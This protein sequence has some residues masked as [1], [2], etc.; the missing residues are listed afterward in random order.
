VALIRLMRPLID[1]NAMDTITKAS[2][3]AATIAATSGENCRTMPDAIRHFP[4]RLLTPDEHALVAEWL[5]AAGDI[6]EAYVSNRY[7]DDPAY[8]RRIVVITKPGDGPSHLVHAPT[9]GETWVVF[10]R[11]PNSQV[12]IFPSLR[13]ALNSIRP[14]LIGVGITADGSVPKV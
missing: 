14:V 2:C 4:A 5:A 10:S 12:E 9:G 6:A 1:I 3:V 13:A 8:Y 7:S 11:S